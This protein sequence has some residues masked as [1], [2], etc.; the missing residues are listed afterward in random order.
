[1]MDDDISFF[2]DL[3]LGKIVIDFFFNCAYSRLDNFLFDKNLRLCSNNSS[4]DDD[5]C[6]SN[7]I[8]MDDDV[9]SS[10][11]CIFGK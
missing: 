6:S 11:T 5:L 9:S 8:M 2:F 1:M 7:T 3:Y 4:N 10:L